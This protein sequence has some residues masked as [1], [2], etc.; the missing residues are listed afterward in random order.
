[1]SR[2]KG[3]PAYPKQ[4]R[5][6]GLPE[7]SVDGRRLTAYDP[8]MALQIVERLAEGDLLKD[9]CAPEGVFCTK[10]TFLRWVARVPELQTAYAAAKEISALSM[11]EEALG[12]ARTLRMAPG[13]AQNVR[14]A[15]VAI[16][17]LRWSAARRDPKVYGDRGAGQTVVP[18][19]ISTTLNM[20]EGSTQAEIP[21]IYTIDLKAEAS[22]PEPEGPKR[23][24]EDGGIIKRGAYGHSK[25]V[26][27]TPRV[28]MDTD[29]QAMKEA[30][31]GESV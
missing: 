1:M 26:S 6:A 3:I 25:K 8:G 21:D 13:T 29:I 27:L 11:E 30:Q 15:E 22:A 9:I 23:F 5:L 16:N 14:A 19:H 31:R 12:L 17:Q 28:P 24:P 20:G 10:S 18:I 2:T 4:D 7:A